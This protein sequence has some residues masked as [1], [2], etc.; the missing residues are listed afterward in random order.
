MKQ[1]LA[2]MKPNLHDKTPEA[3]SN[4][5]RGS[6]FGAFNGSWKTSMVHKQS[7]RQTVPK[8]QNELGKLNWLPQ[9]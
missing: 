9:N 6:Y 1:L 2:L 5:C 7:T 3:S 4:N 8:V